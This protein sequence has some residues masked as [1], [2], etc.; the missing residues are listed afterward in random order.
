MLRP[1]DTMRARRDC[2]VF[3]GHEVRSSFERGEQRFPQIGPDRTP[4]LRNFHGNSDFERSRGGARAA[5]G[6][7]EETNDPTIAVW[8]EL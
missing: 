8:R 7:A 4:E 6:E 1:P 3:L 5:R 2:R